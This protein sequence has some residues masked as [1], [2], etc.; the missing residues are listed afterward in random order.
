VVA[1]ERWV[2]RELGLIESTA[3]DEVLPRLSRAADHGALWVGV[4]GGL[5]MSG[6]RGRRAAAHGLVALSLASAVTNVLLKR[7]SGR[8]RPPAGLVPVARAPRRVPLTTSF[9]SG[10]AASAA[11]FTTAVVLELPW[12]AVPLLPL[13]AAVAASRVVIGV[14]YPSDV[15][16]G[17]AVG[18]A[19]AGVTRRRCG[20][21][22]PWGTR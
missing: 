16:A 9:P 12:T 13:A 22:G 4:A 21:R 6:R 7:A 18:V 20:R 8:R 5:A 19:V 14:H 2:A 17:V 15:V 10:H 11:A 3:L 1:A